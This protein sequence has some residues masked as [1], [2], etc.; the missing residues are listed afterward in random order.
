MPPTHFPLTTLKA[1][2]LFN[3]DFGFVAGYFELFSLF[4]FFGGTSSAFFSLV[5]VSLSLSEQ[6]LC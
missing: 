3:F 5:P 2:R 1:E 6:L 4:L